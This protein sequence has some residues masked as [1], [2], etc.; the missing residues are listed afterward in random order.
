ML[1]SKAGS[2]MAGRLSSP[3]RMAPLKGPRTFPNFSPG[4]NVPFAEVDTVICLIRQRDFGFFRFVFSVLTHNLTQNRKNAGGNNGLERVKAKPH[5]QKTV[6]ESSQKHDGEFQTHLRDKPK[7]LELVR[8]RGDGSEL[9]ELPRTGDT[10]VNTEL[11]HQPGRDVP[12]F[13]RLP[14]G[15]IF[16]G[17][18]LQRWCSEFYYR[19]AGVWT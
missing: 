11:L 9:P 7:V 2:L 5:P 14:H 3:V 1:A 13:R 8:R 12:F 17:K 6:P 15:E 4:R 19:P 18:A 10:A 16:H